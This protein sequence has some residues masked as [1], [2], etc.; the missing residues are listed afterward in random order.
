M[1]FIKLFNKIG[2]QRWALTSTTPVTFIVSKSELED[3]ISKSTDS[4]ISIPL[5][6]K[7]KNTEPKMYFG[8]KENKH[9]K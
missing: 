9:D 1:M 4:D 2:K 6:L 7:F 3:I 8:I 5:E